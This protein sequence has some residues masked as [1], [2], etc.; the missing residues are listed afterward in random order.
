VCLQAIYQAN[1]SSGGEKSKERGGWLGWRCTETRF[2]GVGGSRT[3][4]ENQKGSPGG[5]VV[6]GAYFSEDMRTAVVVHPE[7]DSGARVGVSR[8][9]ADSDGECMA[10]MENNQ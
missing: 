10:C 4:A 8:C 1:G 6:G 3:R 7:G 5:D 9:G 2:V